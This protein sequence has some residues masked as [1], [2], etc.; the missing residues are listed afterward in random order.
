M[1]DVRQMNEYD[2]SSFFLL[3]WCVFGDGLSLDMYNVDN[4]GHYKQKRKGPMSG[5][6]E[7]VDSQFSVCVNWRL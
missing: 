5:Y 7:L 2:G 3:L 1:H 6:I 4:V